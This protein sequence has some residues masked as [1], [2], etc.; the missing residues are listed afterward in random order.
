MWDACSEVNRITYFCMH[1]TLCC[2]L[3]ES[4]LCLHSEGCTK[5]DVPAGKALKMKLS[6]WCVF[7]CL[8]KSTQTHTA[9]TT[10]PLDPTFWPGNTYFL[11]GPG[12]ALSAAQLDV[13]CYDPQAELLQHLLQIRST[14]AI[15]IQ[16]LGRSNW[17]QRSSVWATWVA[18][19]VR[20]YLQWNS[21]PGEF[22]RLF[23]PATPFL[24]PG[25][26]GS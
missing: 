23:S 7:E 17:L 1:R 20:Y 6:F 22:V 13:E 16:R 11:L 12:L 4:Y 15:C 5:T 2:C 8:K 9:W 18:V 19:E 3:H 24:S 14:A 26:R 10:P 25:I 21:D